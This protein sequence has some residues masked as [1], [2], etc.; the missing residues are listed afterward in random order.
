AERNAQRR[1]AAGESNLRRSLVDEVV[2]QHEVEVQSFRARSASRETAGGNRR[3]VGD[4]KH[5]VK[6]AASV[7]SRAAHPDHREG[8]TVTGWQPGQRDVGSQGD[9]RTGSPGIGVGGVG[10]GAA[11]ARTVQNAACRGYGKIHRLLNLS[12]D[13]GHAA[14]G[15]YQKLLGGEVADAEVD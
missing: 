15:R 9:R 4:G 1:S 12:Q 14:V 11:G 7:G 8:T 2:G 13:V 10:S 3:W 5:G 6:A